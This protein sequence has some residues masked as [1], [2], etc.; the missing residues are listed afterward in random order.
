MNPLRA[1]FLSLSRIPPAVMILLIVGLA[2]VVAMVINNQV[3]QQTHELEAQ[4]AALEAKMSQKATVVYATKDIQE[5]ATISS[6]ALEEKQV[7]ASTKPVDALESSGMAVGRIAKTSIAVGNIVSAHDLAPINLA[8]GFESKIKDGYR[9]V[10]FGVDNTSGVAGFIAPGSHVDII[11]SV[12]SGADVKAAPILSD[13]E[14]I[15]VGTT[16]QRAPNSAAGAAAANPAS[17]VTVGVSPVD[18]N[19]L[20]KSN[21]SGKL[22]LTLRNDK[23]H[24]P[25]AVVDITS[26][27]AKSHSA[28]DVASLPPPPSSLPPLPQGGAGMPGLPALAPPPPK[29]HEVEQWAASKKDVITVPRM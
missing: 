28:S 18:A 3:G 20:I 4:K 14:V 29:D 8:T 22:Y 6:D 17:S 1:L 16:Y 26:L 25:V 13:V 21:S 2:V 7:D 5:G 15:A 27:Y 24:T 10:T 23:D 19:K 11:A 9:A 12:G